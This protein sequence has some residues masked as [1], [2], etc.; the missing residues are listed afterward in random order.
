MKKIG[1][2]ICFSLLLFFASNVAAEVHNDSF[3]ITIGTSCEIIEGGGSGY[4]GGMW[5]EYDSGWINEWFYDD[6]LDFNRGKII[7]IEFDLVVL[8]PANSSN[9][10]FAV[11]WST[12]E[13]SYLGYGTQYPPI[14]SIPEFIE[15]EHIMRETLLTEC[16]VPDVVTHYV[17]DYIVYDYNPEWVSIDVMGVNF[18]VTNGVITH[19]CVVE[20]EEESWGAIKSMY[21]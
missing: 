11:N 2:V 9:I 6:P 3:F 14:P 8:D 10:C 18:E 1:I 21:R 13:W 12:P 16:P 5:Y 4:E 19:E 15:E 20:S 7:H 17:F